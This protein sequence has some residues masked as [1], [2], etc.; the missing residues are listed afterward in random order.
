MLTE[1][2]RQALQQAA[3]GFDYEPEVKTIGTGDRIVR[4]DYSACNQFPEVGLYPEFKQAF[5]SLMDQACARLDDYPFSTPLQFTELV[6]QRYA[7]GQLGITP[8]RDSLRAINLI[9]LVNL[10]GQAEFYRCDDRQGTNAVLLDTNPGHVIF[11]RA[12]GFLNTSVRPF[13]FLTNIRSIRYSLGLRQ[14][15]ENKR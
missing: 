14:R 3:E 10:S 13:H 5:Q 9:A 1:S 15:I 8:H 11:L 7:P 4:T 2:A 6:L 12:P